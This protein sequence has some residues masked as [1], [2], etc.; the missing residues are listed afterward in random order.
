LSLAI[1]GTPKDGFVQY[2]DKFPAWFGG[3]IFPSLQ[4]LHVWH[5]DEMIHLQASFVSLTA[6]TELS[7]F[8]VGFNNRGEYQRE[9]YKATLILDPSIL[10]M[11]TLRRLNIIDCDFK[12]L[13]LFF[14]PSLNFM[15]I[16]SCEHLYEFPELSVTALP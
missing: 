8:E 1:E 6:L 5:L 9:T 2:L 16:S 4:E 11:T 13:P 10:Q 3:G 12:T 7:L 15:R 14:M